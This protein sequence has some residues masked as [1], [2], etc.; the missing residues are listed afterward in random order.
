M[1]IAIKVTMLK[2]IC[3]LQVLHDPSNNIAM[4]IFWFGIEFRHHFHNKCHVGMIPCHCKHDVGC[5]Q[6]QHMEILV[7][8]C[9]DEHP[10]LNWTLKSTCVPIVL[11]IF[12]KCLQ[13]CLGSFNKHHPLF[14]ILCYV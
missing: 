3:A 5:P 14:I 11:T 8:C 4:H 2:F 12:H 9:Q 1:L 7:F 6:F 10:S 13:N